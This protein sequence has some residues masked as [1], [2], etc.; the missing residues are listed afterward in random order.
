MPLCRGGRHLYPPLRCRPRGQPCGPCATASPVQTTQSAC[1][2]GRHP[3][4]QRRGAT[5]GTRSTRR[6]PKTRYTLHWR[7]YRG[8]TQHMQ[9]TCKVSVG[10]STM[11]SAPNAL[12]WSMLRRGRYPDDRGSPFNFAN[13]R[14]AAAGSPNSVGQSGA[15][16]Q[17]VHTDTPLIN[18]VATWRGELLGY[19]SS[20]GSLAAAVLC[21]FFVPQRRTICTLYART[22][23]TRS[24]ARPYSRRACVSSAKHTL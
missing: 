12:S 18:P 3:Q 21:A 20:N 23:V 6:T 11:S 4:R 8:N 17:F 5:S 14:P 2:T 16:T 1:N 22:S 24:S 19:R 13:G 7:R 10:M 9:Y 15:P